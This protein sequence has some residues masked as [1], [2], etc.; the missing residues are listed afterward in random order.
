[1][2]AKKNEIVS[3]INNSYSY[4]IQT[5]SEYQKSLELYN[6]DFEKTVEGITLNFKK[7]NVSIT[8]FVD[9][10]ESYN[11]VLAELMRIKTQLVISAEQIN[12]LTGK[13]IY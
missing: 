5:V 7:R 4:Y 8:E 13:D 12:L 10:F 11:D 1:M 6:D 9:F 2:L 3:R